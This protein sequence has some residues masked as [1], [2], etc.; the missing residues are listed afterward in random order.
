MGVAATIGDVI[1]RFSDAMR[2]PRIVGIQEV[3]ARL[4][5]SLSVDLGGDLWYEYDFSTNHFG[6]N[7]L[8]MIVEVVG[9]G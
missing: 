1:S 7:D 6:E 5:P 2:V 3:I 4:R 8:S 9:N